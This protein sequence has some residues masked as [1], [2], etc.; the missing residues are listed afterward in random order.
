M[1]YYLKQEEQRMVHPYN[2]VSSW[3][4]IVLRPH[5]SNLT[6]VFSVLVRNTQIHVTGQRD[7]LSADC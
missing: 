5:L 6:F 7:N 4:Q 3:K 1:V 2:Q